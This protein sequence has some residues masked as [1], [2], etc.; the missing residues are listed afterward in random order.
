MLCR[1]DVRR[2]AIP[3]ATGKSN[4]RQ[5]R[6]P[7]LR[8]AAGYRSAH[9]HHQIHYPTDNGVQV[10]TDKMD[11]MRRNR[12]ATNGDGMQRG[13]CSFDYKQSNFETCSYAEVTT[14]CIRH[15]GQ[16]SVVWFHICGSRIL[17][18]RK[19]VVR[20]P[21]WSWSSIYDIQSCV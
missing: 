17:E 18:L 5:K 3:T 6:P 10:R 8:R 1:A 21:H 13:P 19:D 7:A 20:N 15:L 11:A 4:T 16:G 9:H 12:L 2:C 14:R